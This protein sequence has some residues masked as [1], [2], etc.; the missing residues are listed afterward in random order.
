M[1]QL[2][3]VELIVMFLFMNLWF[4]LAIWKKKNDIADIVWG[5]GFIVTVVC[6]LLVSHS[7]G[8]RAV[9]VSALV[10]VWGSR[11]SIRILLRNIKKAEDPRYQQWRQEWG[12]SFLLRTY[13]QIFMLQGLLILIISVPVLHIIRADNIPLQLLDYLGA[14]I[15]GCG[16]FFEIVGDYQLDRFK[17]NPVNKGRIMKY[18]LWRYSRHP[19]YFGEVLLWW[20]I[21]L[22]S[23][24][25][26]N[27][28]LT[29]VGP[30]TITFLILKVSGI[31]L[32]EKRSLHKEEFQ[33]YM[34]STSVFVP[35]P[36]KKEN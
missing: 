2:F 14:A 30:A 35:M 23:L 24:H 36:P 34:K 31:P 7:S 10:F 21:F 33:K 4:G 16:F 5:L 20:G 28:Y 6:A 18:G 12:E 22:M 29:V 8:E 26:E 27:G 25:L 17:N 3:K 13:L 19:N 15:W 1:I 11:L 9:L 32:A